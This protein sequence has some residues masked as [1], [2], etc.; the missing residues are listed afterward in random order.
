RDGEIRSRPRP[1]TIQRQ[2]R[3]DVVRGSRDSTPQ[4]QVVSLLAGSPRALAAGTAVR[5]TFS[6]R[7]T[8]GPRPHRPTPRLPPRERRPEADPPTAIRPDRRAA[9]LPP[10]RPPRRARPTDCGPSRR[11]PGAAPAARWTRERRPL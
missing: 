6:E 5:R 8:P 1:R 9:G 4:Q 2:R 11:G 3:Q 7:R 10:P